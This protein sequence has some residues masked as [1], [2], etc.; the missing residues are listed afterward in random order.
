MVSTRRS[1]RL[2]GSTP[3]PPGAFRADAIAS[4]PNATPSKLTTVTEDQ[5]IS[6][7]TKG[8]DGGRI[9]PPTSSKNPF[10]S[11][12]GGLVPWT[13]KAKSSILPA[14]SEM[15]P[16]Q[17]QKSTT[18]PLEEA[19]WL[20]FMPMVPQ[21]EP[22]K[23]CSRELTDDLAVAQATPT[24]A[25]QSV[26]KTSFLSPDFK[27][28]FQH[29]PSVESALSPEARRL[30]EETRGE[31][32]K[33]RAKMVAAKE[34]QEARDLQAENQPIFGMTDTLGGR[35]IAKPKGRFSDAHKKQFGKMDSIANHPSSFRADPNR[36]YNDA[37][38]TVDRPNKPL[39][40]SHSKADLDTP[41]KQGPGKT[42]FTPIP[43]RD[44]SLRSPTKRVKH[45]E[46]AD[47]STA[48]ASWQDSSDVMDNKPNT[49]QT[50]GKYR[51]KSGI[52]IPLSTLTTPTKS[53][54]ARSQSAKTLKTKTSIPILARSPSVKN[55]STKMLSNE[56]DRSSPSPTK[57]MKSPSL[58]SILRQGPTR[59][60][61]DDP[62]KVAAGT[63]LPTPKRK[64]MLP[65]AAPATAPVMKHVEFTESTKQLDE[66]ASPTTAKS[67]EA[68]MT[69]DS[70]KSPG[71]NTVEYPSLA[72]SAEFP[73]TKAT[74][75]PKA[76]PKSLQHRRQTIG[77]APS[78]TF[79]DFTFRA[80]SA[81][82]FAAQTAASTIRRVRNSDV[83]TPPTS[84]GSG[85]I[86]LSPQKKRK[87]ED[88][89]EDDEESEK[90]NKAE[91][92]RGQDLEDRPSK[93]MRAT[94][95][96]TDADKEKTA[97]TRAKTPTKSASRLAMFRQDKH[98]EK[99]KDKKRGNGLTIARLNMLATPKTRK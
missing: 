2:Q 93:K 96:A 82:S 84:A 75:R 62:S 94:V 25:T 61:S 33:I 14:P 64:S 5:A 76:V 36:F 35:K 57:L 6:T 16:S 95:S 48:R 27:F 34:K 65:Q 69:T 49:P 11:L 44:T 8:K 13:P 88:L 46:S 7:P 4:T 22:P 86:P 17:H 20:G 97:A 77:P 51:I 98:R 87:L 53:S 9:R 31:A 39:K 68:F 21:T 26:K 58:K 19:R 79:G 74:T 70:L 67:T 60:Y 12:L 1:S 63:H 92:A 42:L 89:Q 50:T 71:D 29:Q 52:P 66:E 81:P 91:F 56:P 47:V 23:K 24:R 45:S 90:E 18:K 32:A 83:F 85:A 78:S 99:D 28:D 43:S 72:T 30:M 80:G 37:P 3:Q 10:S 40:R 73:T 55:I 38:M 41:M 15:H 59:L 54:I